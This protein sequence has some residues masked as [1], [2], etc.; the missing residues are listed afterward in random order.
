AWVSGNAR[1]YGDAQVFGNA[2]VFGDSRVSDNAVVCDNA[3][4]SGYAQ[5]SG[6]ARVSRYDGLVTFGPIGSREGHT[7]YAPESDTIMCGCFTGTLDEFAQRVDEEHGDNIHGKRYRAL[8]EMFRS[9]REAFTEQVTSPNTN[10][11]TQAPCTSKGFYAIGVYSTK[12]A[13]GMGTRSE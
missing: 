6:C 8:I 9:Y 7:S 11:T 13:V 2:R 4:V 5:V 12:K 3:V 1:V 10:P